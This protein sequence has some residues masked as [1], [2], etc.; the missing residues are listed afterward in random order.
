MPDWQKNVMRIGFIPGPLDTLSGEHFP[1]LV[2]MR[3]NLAALRKKVDV[4][5]LT[6]RRANGWYMRV[7][8]S[9]FHRIVSRHCTSI[10]KFLNSLFFLA[11]YMEIRN[12][13]N[14]ESYD[15]FIVRC[16]LSNYFVSR[17]L[18][19]KGH[20][21][22][23][24]THALGHVERKEYGQDRVFP[25]YFMI[26]TYL[27]KRVLNWAHQ[28]TVVSESLKESLAQLGINKDRIHVIHNGVDLNKF[29]YTVNPQ[30][31]IR[32]YNLENRL[33]VG[34]VGSFA[35]YHG[36]DIMLDVGE[37]LGDKWPNVVFILVG[38][39]VHGPD[40]PMEVVRR[41]G[42]GELFIFAGEVPHPRIPLH[43][44]AMDIAMIPDFN[45]YGSP[46]KLFEY[47]AMKK[48][49][50]APDVPPIREVVEDGKTAILFERGNAPQAKEA[51]ER[52]IEDEQLRQDLGEE[53]HEEVMRSHTWERNAEVIAKI[54]ESMI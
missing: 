16:S 36:L 49:I 10:R 35:R 33:V 19:S 4:N 29:D 2:H 14:T 18:H 30:E 26:I 15:L 51:I 43:I 38:K 45:T 21:I 25:L 7:Q 20:K 47:M 9:M 48:P 8:E 32:K 46:M 13:I 50:V 37:A 1:H 28:I 3:E 17:Y 40:N 22:L 34:F 53:A 39:N 11:V 31:I 41:R 24:E 23:L 54:A 44:A 5:I 52:L 27:E 42:L 6:P 12:D